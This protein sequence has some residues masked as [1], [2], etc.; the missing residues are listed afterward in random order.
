MYKYRLMIQ[1]AATREIDLGVV[2]TRKNCKQVAFE[3]LVMH[4]LI[5][6]HTMI[7]GPKEMIYMF[8]VTVQEHLGLV[9]SLTE[10]M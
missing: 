10:G 8:P 9:R 5:I 7:V 2:C 3:A 6:P 1:N 4:L